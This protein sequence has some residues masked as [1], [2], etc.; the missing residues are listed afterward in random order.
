MQR[1]SNMPTIRQKCVSVSTSACHWHRVSVALRA[2]CTSSLI[3][4]ATAQLAIAG[5]LA[6]TL[7][8]TAATIPSSYRNQYRGCAGRLLSVGIPAEAA[9][10]AC[11][12][13]LRP[14]DLSKCVVEI[15][16][17]TELAAEDAL[18]S[19]RQVRRPNEL[20]R[21][22]VGIS[23][24]QEEA[25]PSVLNYCGRSLLPERFAECV[26]GL[27]VEADFAPTD[28]MET[29]ID[30]S[31][32]IG[33]VA[34]NFVPGNQTP[35]IDPNSTPVGPEEQT[36]LIQPAPSIPVPQDLTPLEPDPAPTEPQN[37]TPQDQQPTPITTSINPER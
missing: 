28:A 32:V 14:Q 35:L 12:E 29:C 11:A 37:Q 24:N 23:R 15:E 5:W 31:D 6:M 16:R 27:R 34:P 2:D 10:S 3:Q 4:F 20:A 33:E 7:S 19:C 25:I 8:S 1:R 21:C 36:P 13:A 18:S 30:A 22:V 26:V 17:Q 9:A